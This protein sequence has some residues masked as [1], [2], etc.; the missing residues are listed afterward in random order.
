VT[1]SAINIQKAHKKLIL[2]G[3]MQ[4]GSG[5]QTI[6]AIV[7]KHNLQKYILPWNNVCSCAW[8]HAKS[9]VNPNKKPH[10][11]IISRMNE[12]PDKMVAIHLWNEV[13]RRK[14][15]NKNDTFHPESLYEQLKKKYLHIAMTR[16]KAATKIQSVE[17]GRKGRAKARRRKKEKQKKTIKIMFTDMWFKDINNNRFINKFKE[18][19]HF[20]IDVDAKNP[21][22]VIYS[23]FG[24]TYRNYPNAKKIFVCW[25]PINFGTSQHLKD[26]DYSLT[27]YSDLEDNK[28]HFYF[29]PLLGKFGW[30]E[31]FIENINSPLT[32]PKKKF[33]CFVVSNVNGTV[34]ARERV[35]FFKELCK[36][37]KVDSFGGG[38]RNCD[39]KIPGRYAGEKWDRTYL[40]VIGEYK[41]MITFENVGQNGVVTEKIYN[42]FKGNTIPIYWGNQDIYKI[43]NKGSFINCHDFENFQESIDYIK[44]VDSD[45]ELYYTILNKQKLENTNVDFYRQQYEGIWKKVLNIT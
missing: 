13:W 11:K 5:P 19:F 33:C 39:V 10:P 3:E 29:T 38:L 28:K 15:I 20:N 45:D 24:K 22:Y 27:Y 23:I 6:K 43:F 4:W 44:K 35:K 41:F 7:E 9:I 26:C 34:G 25:E 17:R 42:A 18:D 30:A 16:D 21:D 37:K 14:R 36:Y 1:L 40:D 32:I 8:D 2:S 31:N 12:I